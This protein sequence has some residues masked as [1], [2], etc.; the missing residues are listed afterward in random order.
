MTAPNMKSGKFFHDR[1]GTIHGRICGL[2]MVKETVVSQP[3]LDRE[4]RNYLKLI[5]DPLGEAYELG[6]A[7]PKEKDGK[8][9]YSV[10]IDSPLFPAPLHAALFYDHDSETTLNLVWNRSGTQR[11]TGEPAPGTEP[12]SSR[13]S[14]RAVASP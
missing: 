4:G 3:A 12:S 8:R 2:G 14:T 11:Q 9:Y 5:G 1:E 6:A 7:F 13:R 10:I